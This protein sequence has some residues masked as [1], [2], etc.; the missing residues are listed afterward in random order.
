MRASVFQMPSDRRLAVSLRL[1]DVVA[2]S[3]FTLTLALRLCFHA[4]RR[5]LVS[6]ADVLIII[7]A[8]ALLLA[9]EIVHYF[10]TDH[11]QLA[12]ANRV[13][14]GVCDEER[15]ALQ[16]PASGSQDDFRKFARPFWNIL[17][18]WFPFLVI[19]M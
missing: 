13:P 19:L 4:L 3:F 7:P 11:R 2:L 15:C 17:R 9:K 16:H 12:S 18:D 10:F 14:G 5:D 1:E 8:V 6:P